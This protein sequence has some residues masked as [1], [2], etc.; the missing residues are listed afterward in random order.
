MRPVPTSQPLP[1]ADAA[2]AALQQELRESGIPDAALLFG[3]EAAQ[4][5]W[6]ITQ[7]ADLARACLLDAACNR[8][9]DAQSLPLAM[10]Q[11][12]GAE[13]LQL[14]EALRRLGEL[15]LDE[16]WAAQSA[17]EPAQSETLRKMLLAVV[18]DPR[19]VVA[20]LAQQLVR[21]RHSRALL[22]EERRRI[23]WETRELYAPLANR[24]G[25]W[26]LK[27]ELE[28]LAFRELQPGAYH[29]IAT[30]LNEKR[31]A[32]EQ[33]IEEVRET[34]AARLAEAGIEATVLGRAKHIYSIYRKMQ[35]KQL[36]FDQVF[37]VRGV[38]VIVA[39]V[40]DC[41]AALGIVHGLWPFLPSE[42]DDY[43]ATPKGNDYRSIHTAVTGPDGRPLE[44]QIR[45]AEM[46]AQA[47]L[48]VAAHWRYKEGGAPDRKYE[49]KIQEVRELLSGSRTPAEGDNLDRL[50]QGLF[51]DR[52]YAMTPKG[53]VVDMPSGGTPL[54]FAFHL[55]SS[56]GER[57][58]GAKVNG[59]I[60]PL[61]HQVQSGDVV[62]IL[63]GKTP[64]PSR[65]WLSA[66]AGYLVSTRARSKLRAYFRRL[67]AAAEA[68]PAPQPAPQPSRNRTTAPRPRSGGKARSPVEI[69]G[70]GDLPI[71]LARCCAPIRPQPIRGYLTLGRGVTIHRA[72]CATLSGMLRQKPQ[73]LLQVEWAA[74][75]D[76]RLA[77]RIQI[78]AFDRRGLLRDISDLIAEE[79]LS[80]E[81]V[82]SDTD[83]QDRIARFEV[84]LTVQDATELSRLQRR[85]ARIPNVFRVR[86]AR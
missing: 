15:N 23:A 27:W 52:V 3:R 70:V 9:Q 32:R 47:E 53:E 86:R 20:R 49:R 61:T 33:F 25:V 12:A 31:A 43:I 8:T 39:S 77:A 16:H 57:C 40:A 46:Q 22:P 11:A 58:K 2:F 48:G 50:T 81:G 75:S 78:E 68:P 14:R 71:T 51:D 74:R 35:R 67:D 65:D 85:L 7:D 38:R 55:H 60:V 29:R 56:L 82:S 24:L 59:R 80:I 1:V 41:Y 63:T 44:I 5:V 64:A 18:G 83:P 72:D 62:E 69:E 42:F 19:L 6:E 13:A 45:T 79:H 76:T 73:R 37:D 10:R 21:A 26:T 28:D 30:A 34:L 66:S 84:R 4:L 17:L 54:D 36:T